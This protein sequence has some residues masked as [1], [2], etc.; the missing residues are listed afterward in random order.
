MLSKYTS[1]LN[2]ASKHPLNAVKTTLRADKEESVKKV[3][4]VYLLNTFYALPEMVMFF[5]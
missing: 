5:L 4:T 1:K 2:D 3:F